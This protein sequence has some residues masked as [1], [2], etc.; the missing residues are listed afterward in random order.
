MSARRGMS[1]AGSGRCA[2]AP[3]RM[4]AGFEHLD[5]AVHRLEVVAQHGQLRLALRDR[6]AVGA[7]RA[8]APRRRGSRRTAAPARTSA[9]RRSGPRRACPRGSAGRV[10]CQNSVRLTFDHATMLPDAS[11]CSSIVVPRRSGAVAAATHG[12]TMPARSR[13]R[14]RAAGARTRRAR[15]RCRSGRAMPTSRSRA[16]ASARRRRRGSRRRASRRGR[17]RCCGPRRARAARAWCTT[18][19]RASARRPRVEDR[20]GA[21]GRRVVDED[22]RP[23]PQRLRSQRVECLLGIRRDVVAR[24]R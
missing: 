9:A 11:G 3:R 4:P 7:D 1:I 22:R 8:R 2:P 14:R 21:I 20:A 19:N 13:R 5:A 16:S 24:A 12:C 17:A 6:R 15:S 10:R 23:V 18:R